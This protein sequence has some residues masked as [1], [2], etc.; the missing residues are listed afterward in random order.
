MIAVNYFCK[1]LH[2]RCFKGYWIDSG[3]EYVSSFEYT[4]ALNILGLLIYLRLWICQSSEYVSHSKYVRVLNMLGLHRVLNVL[5]QFPN[6]SDYAWICLKI[7]EHGGMCLNTLFP[8]I[9]SCVLECVITYFNVY[10]KLE[11]ILYFG[12]TW[13]C[14]LDE[15]KFD[16]LYSSWKYLI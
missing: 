3:S 14:F 8:I 2:C 12:G 5:E 7:P 16:F 10:M 15:T 1:T 11:V 6:M 4:R 13:G 9:I